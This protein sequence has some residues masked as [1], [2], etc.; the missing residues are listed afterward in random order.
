MRPRAFQRI[1]WHWFSSWCSSARYWERY[2]CSTDRIEKVWVQYFKPV[3]IIS[4]FITDRHGDVHIQVHSVRLVMYRAYIPLY[5]FTMSISS[6]VP[7]RDA[8]PG[9]CRM[10]DSPSANDA[11]HFRYVGLSREVPIENTLKCHVSIGV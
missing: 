6:S 11:E 2:I 3:A 9:K 8:Q 10:S 5:T 7:A 1:A 4:L